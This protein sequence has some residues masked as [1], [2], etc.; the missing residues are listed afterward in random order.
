[1]RVVWFSTGIS[2]FVATYLNKD[3]VDKIIYIHIDDQHPD[4]LRFVDDCSALL[5]KEIEILQSPYKNVGNVI[6]AF[7]FI[8]SAYGARCTDILKKRVRK[9]WEYGKSDLTYIWGFDSDEHLRAQ[10]TINSMPKQQHEFPLIDNKIA[11]KE[12]HGIA[13][14]L[15]LKRPVMYEMG[16]NNN[17]CIGCVK[18]G[19]GYWNKI[20][21]DFPE[22]FAERARQER[23]VGK[24]CL[25]DKNGQLFL[26]QLDPDRGH[27]VQL[28][29]P[30]CGFICEQLE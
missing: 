3:N 10:R 8:N 13:E 24:S 30:E 16:Y 2:S 20:R 27:D 17:N 1:M 7:Q 21:R 15:G 6:Q 28:I 14:M 22:V 4:S 26:D 9:E 25:R 12:A 18:G 23:M 29:M 19:I 11:K 5:G